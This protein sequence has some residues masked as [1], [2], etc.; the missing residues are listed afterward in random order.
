M[1]MRNARAWPVSSPGGPPWSDGALRYAGK[2]AHPI[3]LGYG[4]RMNRILLSVAAASILA[5]GCGRAAVQ[6]G[7]EAPRPSIA[8]EAPQALAVPTQAGAPTP[9]EP[10]TTPADGTLDFSAAVGAPSARTPGDFV[11]YRF[12]GSFRKAPLTL[13]ERV[14][15]R[16]GSVLTIDFTAT[17]G[18]DREELRVRIDDGTAAREV[19]SVA[20]LV[21]GVEKPATVEAYDALM[22]RTALAAD[23]NEAL[24]GT[25]D[26]TVDVGGAS[27][28]AKQTTYRVR[29]GKRQATLRTIESALFPWGDVGGEIT[30]GNGQLLYRA[31]VVEAGHDDAAAA[32]AALA[33]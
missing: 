29:V 17:D 22:A 24:V 23:S 31:E 25:E 10:A 16:S 13:T 20:R 28:A 8:K 9:A 30:T 32:A 12:S 21:H 33:Q 18:K 2:W 5:T 14:I 3:E 7:A 6:N 19:V 11:V 1:S 27:L 15:A 4:D 26:V